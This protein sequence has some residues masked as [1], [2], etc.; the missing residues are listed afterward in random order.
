MKW[1]IARADPL[2]DISS[3]SVSSWLHIQ[4]SLQVS[5]NNHHKNNEAESILGFDSNCNSFFLVQLKKGSLYFILNLDLL[6]IIILFVSKSCSFVKHFFPLSLT[7]D[8]SWVYSQA[9]I[10]EA[11][12]SWCY[13]LNAN[14]HMITCSEWQ[15]KLYHL[16][17]KVC[18]YLVINRSTDYL[19]CWPYDGTR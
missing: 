14:T 2:T 6:L 12:L 16:L 10:S 5:K 11:V 9:R 4:R 7:R 8:Q 15:S 17:G 18:R 13:G 19:R 1:R 3:Q